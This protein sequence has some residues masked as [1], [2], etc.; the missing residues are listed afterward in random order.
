MKAKTVV[1]ALAN[2][3]A[4]VEANMLIDNVAEVKA[5]AK[6]DGWMTR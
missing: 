4:E 6:I 3:L 1:D 2:M 5:E